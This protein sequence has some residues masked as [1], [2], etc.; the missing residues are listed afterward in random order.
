[1]A[2]DQTD[3]RSRRRER[4][5]AEILD[6]AWQLARRDGIASVS[7]RELAAMV[8][9]RAPSLYTYFPSKNDLYDAMY[10]QGMQQF[11]DAMDAT[12]LGRD[13]RESLANR[14]RTFARMSLDD[15]AR[16]ELLFHRPIPD[17]VPSAEALQIG[18]D[19]LAATRRFAIE[20]GMRTQ[21]A[22]DVYVSTNRGLIAMQIANDPGGDRWARLIDDALEMVVDHYAS[23]D[24][25][26]PRRPKR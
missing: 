23:T 5:R 14:S 8:G 25:R 1:M 12:P 21:E 7:L 20:A 6:A 16:Y 10:R 17:F 19:G 11:A 18:L 13:A 24:G 26:K 15:P 2:L 4:T 3:A 9:M 22:F